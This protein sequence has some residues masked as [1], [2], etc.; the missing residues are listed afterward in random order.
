[1][2]KNKIVRRYGKMMKDLPDEDLMACIYMLCS[3]LRRRSDN[4]VTMEDILTSIWNIG[5]LV[6][7]NI[8]ESEEKE[9]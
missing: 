1:M 5:K 3:E 2:R 9:C 7:H 4:T 6:D 8:S